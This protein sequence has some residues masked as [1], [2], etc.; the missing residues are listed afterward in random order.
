M[1]MQIPVDD[2][3]RK[4]CVQR[5]EISGL[6]ERAAKFAGMVAAFCERLGYVAFHFFIF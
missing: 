3:A 2:V 6:Q 1:H 4:F 5:P